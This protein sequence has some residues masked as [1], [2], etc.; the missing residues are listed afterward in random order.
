MKKN[1][2]LSTLLITT[3]ATAGFASDMEGNTD[4][5]DH[6]QLRIGILS[7]SGTYIVE[8]AYGTQSEDRNINSASGYE[9]SLVSAKSNQD[10]FDYRSVLTL[11]FNDWTNKYDQK[12][13]DIMFLGEGEFAYNINKNVSPFVGYYG[14]IGTTDATEGWTSNSSSQLTYDLGLFVGISGDFYEALGYYAKYN[15]FSTKGFNVED[16]TL[17]YRMSPTT[18]RIGV[19]YTF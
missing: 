8:N 12:F 4:T 6:R 13:S 10:G 3:L 2:L 14:G 7:G 1:L 15:F 19:S 18:L 16:D 5:K 9:I 11:Q 17:G